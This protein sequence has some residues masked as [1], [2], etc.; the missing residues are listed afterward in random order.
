[1]RRIIAGSAL[2]VTALLFLQPASASDVVQDSLE[3]SHKTILDLPSASK[4][5]K[6]SGK[7]YQMPVRPKS[8][9][10][11]HASQRDRSF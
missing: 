7:S 10:R 2:M 6:K 11:Q 5:V 3:L 9:K 8:A 1:M 4:A